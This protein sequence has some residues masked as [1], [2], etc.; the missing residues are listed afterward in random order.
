MS[1]YQ[2]ADSIREHL[3][4]QISPVL[5]GRSNISELAF[6]LYDDSAISLFDLPLVTGSLATVATAIVEAAARGECNIIHFINAH[7]VN[8]MLR[9]DA[10]LEELKATDI[11]L[12]DGS[13]LQLSAG[14]AGS[15]K[16][17][18]LNGTDLFPHLCEQAAQNG[19]SIFLLGGEP[20]TASAAAKNMRNTIPDLEFAGTQNGFFAPDEVTEIIQKINQS[21]ASI[22]L[23][24]MG[25][26]MQEKWI[27][28]YRDQIKTPII[29]GVGGLFDYYSGKIARAPLLVRK[30]GM[31][32][33]WRLAMEP[34]RLANRYLLG[35]ARFIAHAVTHAFIVRGHAKRYAAAAKRT[36]DLAIALLALVLW[37]PLAAAICLFIT[38][39]D[40]GS[41]FFRQTRIGADGKPF[42]IWKFRSMYK[43]AEERKSQLA[44]QNERDSVCFK[45]KEDPRITKVGK[46]IRRTSLDELPQ[47]LNILTG[48]MSVVG[49]RPAL[50]CEVLSYA[51]RERRRLNGKPGLTCTWQ[52]SGRADIPFEEQVEMDLDY[53]EKQSVW[54]DLK[55]ITQTVPAVISG[56]GAY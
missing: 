45:M 35:N 20:G 55:L 56:R 28:R 32:W 16:M 44:D 14:L 5:I 53:L 9:D 26:P 23:V 41:P 27:A 19:Q 42:K 43:N 11:L 34:R 21:G 4:R 40:R 39:E 10:Y 22:L 17:D 50:P 7:C 1:Q 12:P 25:V 47:I 31:E 8:Q 13:G 15:G 49:P 6:R 52:V 37:G 51:E 36:L 30:M 3:G 2:S 18:N 46:L 38:M 48:Q 33:V 54:H 29:M 24:G